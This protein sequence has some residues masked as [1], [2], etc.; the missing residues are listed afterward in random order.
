[1]RSGSEARGAL[2]DALRTIENWGRSGTGGLHNVDVASLLN[3]A[4][5]SNTNSA[6]NSEDGDGPERAGSVS[7][8]TGMRAWLGEMLQDANDPRARKAIPVGWQQKR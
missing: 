4:D 7:S 8:T 2:E 6:E 5:R 1:M 3:L